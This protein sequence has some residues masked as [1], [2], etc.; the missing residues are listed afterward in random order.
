MI[1]FHPS[2]CFFQMIFE[3]INTVENTVVKLLFPQII[4]YMLD[5][6]VFR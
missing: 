4:P 6:C 2:Q 3:G 5:R 1:I